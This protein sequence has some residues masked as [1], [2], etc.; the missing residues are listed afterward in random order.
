ME[1]GLAA[2]AAQVWSREVRVPAPLPLPKPMERSPN[3]QQAALRGRLGQHGLAE[4][5]RYA[6]V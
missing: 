6:H 1:P 3:V 4:R 5:C 2:L